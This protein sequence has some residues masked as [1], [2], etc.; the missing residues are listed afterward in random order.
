MIT[1]PLITRKCD[2]ESGYVCA[3]GG[4]IGRIAGNNH[5]IL[6]RFKEL[7]EMYGLD[8]ATQSMCQ[9]SVAKRIEDGRFVGAKPVALMPL[10]QRHFT[11][12][13]VSLS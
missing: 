11:P 13:L 6:D 4:F 9:G 8:K 10:L 3:T 12:T 7:K 1:K 5:Q 2:F